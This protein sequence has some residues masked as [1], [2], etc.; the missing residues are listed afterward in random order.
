MQHSKQRFSLRK[1]KAYG[2]CPLLLGAFLVVTPNEA[3]A[4]GA[5]QPVSTATTN[6]VNAV[7]TKPE[8]SNQVNTN[9]TISTRSSNDVSGNQNVS[10]F[11]DGKSKDFTSGDKLGLP[12]GWGRSDWHI[13]TYRKIFL[14]Y[15][16]NPNAHREDSGNIYRDTDTIDTVLSKEGSMEGK[17]LHSLYLDQFE[18]MGLSSDISADTHKLAIAVDTD[19]EGVVVNSKEKISLEDKNKKSNGF[20]GEVDATNR[21]VK[22]YYQS[23]TEKYYLSLDST[24]EWNKKNRYIPLL[25]GENPLSV[26]KSANG[27]TDFSGKNPT[28]YTYEDLKVVLDP[29]IKTASTMKDLTLNSALF[30]VATVLDENYNVLDTTVVKPDSN[31][32]L[33]TFS[34]ENPNKLTTFIVRTVIRNYGVR[35]PKEQIV[36]GSTV[37]TATGEEFVGRMVLKSGDAENLVVDKQ[38]AFE[39]AKDK[40]I[41]PNEVLRI[42]GSIKGNIAFDKTNLT[43]AGALLAL[44]MPN[45]AEIEENNSLNVLDIDFAFNKVTYNRNSAD[46]EA[47]AEQNLG[48]S[49]VVHNNNLAADEL[50]TGTKP[51]KDVEGDTHLGNLDD[52]TVDGVV[53]KFKG[54][55]TQADGSGQAFDENTVVLEDITV[56]A[57]WEQ[58]AKVVYEFVS[59]T[60]GKDLPESVKELTLKEKE[61]VFGE[62]ITPEQPEKTEVAVEG[63]KWKFVSYDK[64]KELIDTV[65]EKF[66][67][68]WVFEEEKPNTEVVVPTEPTKPTPKPEPQPEPK[69]EEPTQ[70]DD[71]TKDS[72][73]KQEK[74]E[75]PKTSVAPIQNPMSI[76]QGFVG[77]L[78]LL[79]IKRK[80]K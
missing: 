35:E 75:L 12:D 43:G 54:W 53:Y 60:A 10:I 69:K 3:A 37:L 80:K 59:G 42:N 15:S 7:V 66:I 76:Y 51:T 28:N 6:N 65:E 21:L 73:K 44:F 39:L 70:K 36:S 45:N 58:T 57:V 31:S 13:R 50:N 71:K 17:T 29:R 67:G 72:S 38:T 1:N 23:S 40:D 24:F 34:F 16:T 49:L 78:A 79:A 62:E 52:V 32:N 27:V 46:F 25:V 47:G 30:T 9:P 19:S 63:G 2:L 55:N 18:I 48:T 61:V 77:L 5:E 68:T 4:N 56:Y 14:G 64:E 26:I 33:T 74:K 22:D 41:K 8:N 11:I 20:T